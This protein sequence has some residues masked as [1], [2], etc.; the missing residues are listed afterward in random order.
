MVKAETR[1]VGVDYRTDSTKRGE[2]QSC[3]KLYGE[4]KTKHGNMDSL[5]VYKVVIIEK[6]VKK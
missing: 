1:P 2:G 6:R 3:G 5:D 4:K